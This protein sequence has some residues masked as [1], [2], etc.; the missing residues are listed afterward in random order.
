MP[1]D[2]AYFEKHHFANRF[3]ASELDTEERNAFQDHFM[4]CDQCLEQL[5]L[6][7]SFAT[8]I[9]AQAGEMEK[10]KPEGY[11]NSPLLIL[12]AS[13]LLAGNLYLLSANNSHQDKPLQVSVETL[14]RNRGAESEPFKLAKNDALLVLR[15]PL[16]EPGKKFKVILTTPT[17]EPMWDTLITTSER[18]FELGIPRQLLPLTMY[19]LVLRDLDTL[20]EDKYPF[21]IEHER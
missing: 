13:L 21:S 17:G 18:P 16:S 14:T 2:H 20:V 15:L 8:A 7:Q 11:R 19:Q 9:K 1:H 12:A 4:Q 6:E 3:L 5:E 10:F